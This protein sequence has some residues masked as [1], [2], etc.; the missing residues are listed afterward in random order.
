[1]TAAKSTSR[2]RRSA[3][4]GG[5]VQ[6]PKTI[7]EWFA[8]E[9]PFSFRATTAPYLFVIRD[10]WEAWLADHPGAQPPHNLQPFLRAEPAPGGRLAALAASARAQLGISQ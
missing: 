2:R 8:G 4:A 9:R 5:T 3:S 1:M 10:L 6:I 7:A